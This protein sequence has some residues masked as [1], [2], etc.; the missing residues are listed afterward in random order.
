MKTRKAERPYWEREQGWDTSGN[1]TKCGEAGRCQCPHPKAQPQPTHTP[2]NEGHTPTPW[3][4]IAETR[5]LGEGMS[6]AKMLYNQAEGRSLDEAKVDAAFIVRAVNSHEEL[7]KALKRIV[8]INGSTG[9][10]KA[11]VEEFKFIARE[12]IAQAEG[13]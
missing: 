2:K 9:G 4:L 6:L 3:K 12:A 8:E 5:I 13:K 1:C 7:L 10:A 11:L